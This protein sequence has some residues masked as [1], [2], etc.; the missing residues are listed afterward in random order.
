MLV[1]Y[2]LIIF[3]KTGRFRKGSGL[4]NLISEKV[5]PKLKV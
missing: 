3:E 4:F 1:P 2:A 5:W